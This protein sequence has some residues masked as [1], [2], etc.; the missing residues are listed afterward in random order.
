MENN[1]QVLRNDAKDLLF[2]AATPSATNF[3][4]V[5]ASATNAFQ[6]YFNAISGG[7]NSVRSLLRHQGAMFSIIEEILDELVPA[8]VEDR[9]GQFADVRTYARDAAIEYSIPTTYASKRRLYT[10]IKRGAKGGVYRAY[11]LD[12]KVLS[13]ES[14]VETV[15]YRI[16]LEEL[17][18]GK[19]TISELISILADAWVE[20]IYVLVM[21]QLG[22]AAA[23]APTANKSTGVFDEEIFDAIVEVIAT[24]GVPIIMGKRK[25][26]AKMA[27]VTAID[28]GADGNDIRNRGYI[29]IYKGTKTVLMPNYLL[30]MLNTTWLF[31]DST[32]YILPGD[33]KPVKVAFK[34]E[35]FTKEIDNAD[36]SMELH[37]HRLMGV[38]VLFNN[39]IGSWTSFA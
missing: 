8:K 34:G 15:G 24:Y 26:I 39:N 36:G 1:L 12:G 28:G 17:L 2:A 21:E 14:Y 3:A 6:A 32:V 22:T 18:S 30:D 7:D 33:I 23:A 37:N 27:N 10:A 5:N 13:V 25:E 31:T 20:K 4:D 38:T 29:Q 16:T 35:S 19:R 9:I 11:R